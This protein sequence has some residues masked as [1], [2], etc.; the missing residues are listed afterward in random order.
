MNVDESYI[1]GFSLRHQQH[2][3]ST[4][5]HGHGL[6]HFSFCIACG[7]V[8]VSGERLVGDVGGTNARFALLDDNNVPKRSRTLRTDDFPRLS[9]AI[10]TYLA[11][12]DL[13][14]VVHAPPRLLR[15]A[16]VVVV[17][18]QHEELQQ[19]R[20]ELRVLVQRVHHQQ[21]ARLCRNRQPR[22]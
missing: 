12:H 21:H 7:G 18:A 9:A 4:S 13:E 10:G 2:T 5:R 8:A 3:V 15:V 16:G 14:G 11:E 22:R 19:R 20:R 1:G 17:H 6:N